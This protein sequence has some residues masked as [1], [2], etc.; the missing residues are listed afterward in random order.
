M[1]ECVLGIDIGG[2]K[3]AVSVGDRAGNVIAR[4]RRPT[5]PCGVARDDIARLAADARAAVATAGLTLDDLAAIGVS[6]PGPLDPAGRRL[7]GPPNLPGWQDV[8]L[9]DLLEADLGAP[10]TLE[11]DANAAALAEWHFGAAR[12]FRDV[13]YLTM[14]TGVG[15]GLILDGRLYRGHGRAAGEVGHTRIDFRADAERCSCGNRGCL[16]A[17]VGGAA[18][19]RRLRRETPGQSEVARLAGGIERVTPEHVV[20]AARSRD[21]FALSEM[22]RFNEH[23]AR[24][25][26]NLGFT[27]APELVVL[28]TIAAAAGED[29]C[30]EPVRELVRAGL[31]SVIAERLSIRPATLG[32]ELPYRAGLGVALAGRGA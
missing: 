28:G 20:A 13:V 21:S 10:V 11:N 25:I 8:P 14:S 1:G 22:Q 18:W 12:G 31:W 7:L 24:G 2:T 16:E 23:L 29:L 5:D 32:E 19:T 4:T 27:L 17:Y 15:A 9:A 6:A 26:V 3:V 30:L